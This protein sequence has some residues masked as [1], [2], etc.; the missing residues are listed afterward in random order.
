[1]SA[2]GPAFEVTAMVARLLLPCGEGGPAGRVHWWRW[3]RGWAVLVGWL[4]ASSD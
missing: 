4:R 3:W 2:P 1:L